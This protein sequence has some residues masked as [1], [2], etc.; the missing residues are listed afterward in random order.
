MYIHV[1]IHTP[2]P[3]YNLIENKRAFESNAISVSL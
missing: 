2:P 3:L 1:F